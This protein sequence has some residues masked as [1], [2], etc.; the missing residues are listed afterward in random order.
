MLKKIL[1]VIM[2]ALGITVLVFLGLKTYADA[3]FFDGYDPSV[4][5]N[6]EVQARKTLNKTQN[7]FGVEC[8]ARYQEE[9][10][11]FEARPGERVPTIFTF[12]LEGKGPFP[13]IIFLHGSHQEKEFVRKICTPFNEAGFV[14][15]GF[16]QYMRGER[17]VEVR[18][19][20]LFTVFRERTRKTVHDARR[21][22]DYLETRADIDINRIY[23]VGASYGAITGTTV[24]AHDK[25]IK[26]AVLVVGG[27]NLHLL[28]KAPIIRKE[29]PKW[30]HPF[31]GPLIRFTMGAGDP[32]HTA[33]Q[34]AGTPVLMQNG[35]QDSVVIPE[36]GRALYEALGEPKAIQ[37]Y[38]IDHPDIEPDGKAVLKV[39]QEGLEWL[40]KQDAKIRKAQ[41]DSTDEAA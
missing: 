5:L 9:K 1:I 34:T 37:W 7:V 14:M 13:A 22:I 17:K 29:I 33:P 26:V 23:L 2:V 18:L 41:E 28:A 31:M 39:L 21:L 8:P 4:P 40:V 32:I 6:A 24:V 36:S 20:N 30:L 10:V 27:A 38:D 19:S 11:Y 35:T 12:P 16:D 3:H 15:I 25:R